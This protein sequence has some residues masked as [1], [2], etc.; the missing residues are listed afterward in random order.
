MVSL[1]ALLIEA[2]PVSA[3]WNCGCAAAAAWT[4]ASTGPTRSA[5]S[6]RLPVTWN[7]SSAACR[8]AEIWLTLAGSSGDRI[9]VTRPVASI[10]VRTSRIAAW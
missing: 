1:T 9:W 6:L 8:S 5:A 4:A 2:S 7:S 3:I 10:L